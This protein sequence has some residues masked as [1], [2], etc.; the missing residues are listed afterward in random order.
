MGWVGGHQAHLS[1]GP[2]GFARDIPLPLSFCRVPP[3]SNI[4][5]MATL[6]N[7]VYRFSASP[8]KVPMAFLTD[9]RKNN[10]FYNLYENREDLKEVCCLEREKVEMEDSDS[11]TS[12]FTTEL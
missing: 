3:A 12:V 4:V 5:I 7:A 8:M 6:Q 1:L 10:F 11:L 2:L 9:N